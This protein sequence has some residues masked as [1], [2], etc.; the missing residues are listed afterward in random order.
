MLHVYQSN[1]LETLGQVL[2]ERLTRRPAGQ[3]LFCAETIVV[4]NPDMAQW[5]KIQLAGQLGIAANLNFPLPS[6]YLWTLFRL[7]V[8]DKVAE[9]SPF[10]KA[11]MR[12]ALMKLLPGQ[13]DADEFAPLKHYLEHLSEGVDPQAAYQLRLYQLC[14]QIADVFD[15]Y[16][17]Y[18]DR[19]SVV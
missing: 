17:M 6:S 8:A 1:Q 2:A 3:S 11:N 14:N 10:D 18:R 12:W 4:Q 5:L 13:L 7:L 9:Q 16:L 19:K 15:Q